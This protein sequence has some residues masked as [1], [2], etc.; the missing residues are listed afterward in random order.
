MSNKKDFDSVLNHVRTFQMFFSVYQA[1]REVAGHGMQ[2]YQLQQDRT[3]QVAQSKSLASLPLA[4]VIADLHES[5]WMT[6][7]VKM[8]LFTPAWYTVTHAGVHRR[9]MREQVC[10][11]ANHEYST[12]TTK[13][14][15]TEAINRK[16]HSL[17][18]RPD[19]FM[20]NKVWIIFSRS[21]RSRKPPLELHYYDPLH[22]LESR[23]YFM[24][25]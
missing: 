25:P 15:L 3:A 10:A 17:E 8:P 20:S 19:L 24:F 11:R 9:S 4:G 22:L 1:D 16:C 7:Y 12:S 2:W 18:H 5:F 23:Q 13:S 21:F 6:A 14:I